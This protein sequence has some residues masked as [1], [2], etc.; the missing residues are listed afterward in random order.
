[1]TTLYTGTAIDPD[2]DDGTDDDE[3][4]ARP[5]VRGPRM[6]TRR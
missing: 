4:R 3:R 1:V 6:R 2:D 5:F